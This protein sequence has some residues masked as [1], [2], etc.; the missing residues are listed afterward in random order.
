MPSN[1]T[2]TYLV[3]NYLYFNSYIFRSVLTIISLSYRYLSCTCNA[4]YVVWY[5]LIFSIILKHIQNIKNCITLF[6]FG[7]VEIYIC[8]KSVLVWMESKI[9]CIWHLKI[10]KSTTEFKDEW[11]YYFNFPTDIRGLNKDKDYKRTQYQLDLSLA[12]TKPKK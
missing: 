10:H 8:N 2:I 12:K 6:S 1:T 5:P 9:Y 4:I 3:I 11:K 7:C